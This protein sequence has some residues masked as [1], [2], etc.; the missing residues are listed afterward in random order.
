MM[1]SD[2]DNFLKKTGL[3]TFFAQSS[4]KLTKFKNCNEKTGLGS[5]RR[6]GKLISERTSLLVVKF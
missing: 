5:N 1:K 3:L 2:D 6:Y 4:P